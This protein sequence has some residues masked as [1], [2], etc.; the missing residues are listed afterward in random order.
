MPEN[1]SINIP[2][3]FFTMNINQD[4]YHGTG[5]FG[6]SGEPGAPPEIDIRSITG[7]NLDQLDMPHM[8]EVLRGLYDR[9]GTR[10]N[11]RPRAFRAQSPTGTVTDIQASLYH[12]FRV[13][14]DEVI[15]LLHELKPMIPDPDLEDC[16]AARELMIEGVTE[17]VE[18]TRWQG[19][20]RQLKLEGAFKKLKK[21][22]KLLRKR[23]G[24]KED[25]ARTQAEADNWARFV[26]IQDIL[27]DMKNSWEIRKDD[28][29]RSGD[30]SFGNQVVWL[31]RLLGTVKEA[32]VRL[33][34]L[35]KAM[36]VG[37]AEMSTKFIGDDQ[38]TLTELLDWTAEV[39]DRGTTISLRA[40]KDGMF[41][42]SFDLENLRDVYSDLIH[43]IDN[44]CD[45]VEVP[46]SE[47]CEE[48][49][50][51][52]LEDIVDALV[53]A[54]DRA[55]N[56]DQRNVK[57]VQGFRGANKRA[58]H[59]RPQWGHSHH[60]RPAPTFTSQED[61]QPAVLFE[62][63]ELGPVVLG[64]SPTH[65]QAGTPVEIDVIGQ[66]LH[67]GVVERT[68]TLAPAEV[69]QVIDCA[70]I[71]D[72]KIRLL[73]QINPK[74]YGPQD[75]IVL[76]DGVEMWVGKTGFLIIPSE[77]LLSSPVNASE[78]FTNLADGESTMVL[79]PFEI[80]LD[81][82]VPTKR[83]VIEPTAVY[84]VP[85]N[86]DW[87]EKPA[88]T[89]EI[90]DEYKTALH[91]GVTYTPEKTSPEIPLTAQQVT[92]QAQ[93]YADFPPVSQQDLT[94]DNELPA[95]PD[96][97]ETTDDLLYPASYS[98]QLDVKQISQPVDQVE[99]AGPVPDLPEIQGDVSQSPVQDVNEQEDKPKRKGK[100]LTGGSQ[101]A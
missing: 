48:H 38:L 60:H 98:S 47:L 95:E 44:G 68:W 78:K 56:A 28:L 57:K 74:Y 96:D 7:V 75:I 59:H 55:V 73:V 85:G 15:H 83:V 70:H 2:Q 63:P 22:R 31:N 64:I 37:D 94:S 61:I 49:V 14:G 36:L 10:Y 34:F 100:K 40:G 9:K 99:Q 69:F 16:E 93:P 90:V 82:S 27:S 81:P 52:T 86:K 66:N 71:S 13:S 25:R 33:R 54:T 58:S 101:N 45:S 30:E 62:H 77:T 24:L 42:L 20:P 8:L 46:I 32:S 19:G 91:K 5:G 87:S 88:A 80:L 11:Y 17:A 72:M 76:M 4:P 29:D 21:Y 23:F 12:R 79:K 51:Q 35:L 84:S 67:P 26:T 89:Q 97:P 65:A 92:A 50:Y 43:D 3:P 18:E 53:D 6:G 39:C 1:N 41:S